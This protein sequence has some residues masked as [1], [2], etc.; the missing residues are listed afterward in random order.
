MKG[1][2]GGAYRDESAIEECDPRAPSRTIECTSREP[3]ADSQAPRSR[4]ESPLHAAAA[5]TTARSRAAEVCPAS[6][7]VEPD[8]DPV[9]MV[10]NLIRVQYLSSK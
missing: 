9:H 2:K 4:A 8:T 10:S 5:S 3:R 1:V 6:A 7:L